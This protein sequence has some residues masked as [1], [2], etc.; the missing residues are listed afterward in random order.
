MA[1]HRFA[2]LAAALAALLAGAM[3][4]VGRGQE[5]VLA[6][7]MP[8]VEIEL[9]PAVVRA[10]DD[11]ER[12][13]CILFACGPSPAD[14]L[15]RPYPDRSDKSW[16]ELLAAAGG[17][18]E[19]ERAV[20]EA[21]AW[22]AAHQRDD[23]GWSFKHGR[24]DCRHR[25]GE[26]GDFDDAHNAAT[27]LALLPFL[28]AG[29]TH[30]EGDYQKVVRAGL[31]CLV[32]KMRLTP[33]GFSLEESQAGP[34]AHAFGA[35]VLCEAYGMTQ[36]KHLLLPAQAALDH[37]VS[38]QDREQGGWRFRPDQRCNVGLTAWQLLALKAAHKAYLKI[39]ATTVRD[40]SKFFDSVQSDRGA[41][42]GY[43]TPGEEPAATAAGLLCRMYLGWRKEI[44][45]LPRGIKRLDQWG[46]SRHDMFYNFFATDARR[47]YGGDGWKVWNAAL[48]DYLIAAQ[49]DDGHEKG[50]WHFASDPHGAQ[51]GGRLYCTAMAALTLET[52]Y[53]QRLLYPR[54]ASW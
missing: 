29:H 43:S 27:A 24:G 2:I 46:P 54:S 13:D 42:Y 53:R 17:N 36:D 22:L 5:P 9:D 19:S 7:E 16:A 38:T 37:I 39:P 50:S 25:C 51:W 41:A 23:G 4:Q 6:V 45:A 31:Y 15:R 34:Y 52:Y 49:A 26:E 12:P 32:S 35:L 11:V 1:R 47:H 33:H 48:R 40:V 3:F 10:A 30:K 8:S 28:A 20:G 18:A 21:L 14:F 44:P